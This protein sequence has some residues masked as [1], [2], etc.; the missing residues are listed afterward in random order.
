LMDVMNLSTFAQFDMAQVTLMTVLGDLYFL[1]YSSKRLI[2]G[3][4]ICYV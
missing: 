3:M 4:I 2:E 1:A